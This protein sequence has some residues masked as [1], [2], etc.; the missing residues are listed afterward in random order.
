MLQ[1]IPHPKTHARLSHAN[2]PGA[3]LRRGYNLLNRA[4]VTLNGNEPWDMQMHHPKLF[5][6]IFANGTM[7]VGEAYMDSWWDA[8]ALDEFFYRIFASD[9]DKEVRKAGFIWLMLKSR[10]LNNQNKH[11][12]FEVGEA[13][14]DMGN[15]LYRRMLDTHMAYSCG[16]WKDANTLDDAQTAK[17]DLICRKL[18]I[19]KGQRLLDIGCGWG[20]FS[21]FAAQHYGANVVGVTISKEQHALAVERCK[22]LPVDIRLQ[23]YRDIEDGPFDHLIS[24][25]MFEHVGPKN[26]RTYF[27]KAHK[28]LKK[29][30]LFLLHTIGNSTSGKAADPWIDKYI[31][32]NG[33]LPSLK[34]I[35][36]SMETGGLVPGNLFVV[37]DMHNFGA[38]YDHTLMAWWHN[39]DAAWPELKQQY[40]ETFYR[41]WKFYL[42]SLAGAFPA[43]RYQLWQFVLSPRGVESGYTSIR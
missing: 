38:D 26:Y 7:G 6:R 36:D 23:D 24:I 34:Q 10:L 30:G 32:P 5:E 37:E 2:K 35:A 25:G 21:R 8:D 27:E 18:N 29:D 12:A 33:I 16:Y 43:R 4:G 28:L 22:G 9:I 41:M 39:F 40:N 11:K 14:Y 13:H 42:L 3:A 15:I 31:F 20:S 19:Q 17:L 1:T